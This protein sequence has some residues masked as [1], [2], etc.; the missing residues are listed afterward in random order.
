MCAGDVLFRHGTSTG[1]SGMDSTMVARLGSL[2][3]P[4]S[5]DIARYL[6]QVQFVDLPEASPRKHVPSI[7]HCVCGGMHACM[8]ACVRVCA[9]ACMR[10]GLILNAYLH[11]CIYLSTY[12]CARA[13][14]SVTT[15]HAHAPPTQVSTPPSH[16][17]LFANSTRAPPPHHPSSPLAQGAAQPAVPAAVHLLGHDAGGG[18]P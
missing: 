10:A 6:E 18:H 7:S 1:S 3:L 16:N 2:N 8:R 12:A 13:C 11:G 4:S 5:M 15:A 9:R 14:L 17:H